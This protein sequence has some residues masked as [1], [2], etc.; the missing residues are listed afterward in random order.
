MSDPTNSAAPAEPSDS[1]LLRPAN[2]F[3]EWFRYITTWIRGLT[4]SGASQYETVWHAIELRSGIEM[5]E[6][7][8]PAVKRTGKK[9]EIRGVVRP[10]SGNF[11]EG[12]VVIGSVPPGFAPGWWRYRPVA[13]A[14]T[15][16]VARSVIKDDGTIT[17][18]FSNATSGWVSLE[19]ADW[20]VT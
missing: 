8:I 6:L 7:P 10:S 13:S 16:T 14:S 17:V 4:P 9:V 1:S 12:S 20:S 11:P 3:S 15:A 18:S 19:Q 2:S 5:S